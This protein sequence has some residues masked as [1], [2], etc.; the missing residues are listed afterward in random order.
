MRSIFFL[1]VLVLCVL[2]QKPGI[3]PRA[4]LLQSGVPS[5]CCC[6][7]ISVISPGFSDPS[8]SKLWNLSFKFSRSQFVYKA[9]AKLTCNS[10]VIYLR[11]SYEHEETA[12]S[13]CDNKYHC[14]SATHCAHSR[15]KHTFHMYTEHRSM[16]VCVCHT[17]GGVRRRM[18]LRRI[19]RR[20]KLHGE[21]QCCF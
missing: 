15:P 7:G 3:L 17:R 6:F 11:I 10:A 5:L 14:K 13:G 12:P 8:E 19:W 4:A 18:T 9:C 21:G 20:R 1:A 2:V 16:C